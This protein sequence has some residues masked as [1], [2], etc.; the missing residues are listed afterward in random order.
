LRFAIGPARSQSVQRT[1]KHPRAQNGFPSQ[2]SATL[3]AMSDYLSF[4]ILVAA[5]W[6]NRDQQ[7]IIDYLLEENRVYQELLEKRRPR[8]SDDQRRRLAI[9]AKALDANVRKQIANIASPDTLMG[10]FRLRSGPSAGSSL[11][12]NTMDLLLR[13]AQDLR[14]NAGQGVHDCAIGLRTWL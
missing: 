13:R 4:L 3:L 7:K 8:F 14:Q 10:W 12:R 9:K 11:P 5:G 6:I 1:Q 2:T